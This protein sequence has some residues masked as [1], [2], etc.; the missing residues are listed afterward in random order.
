LIN[1][2]PDI[3]FAGAGDRGY[4]GAP[5]THVRT[6]RYACFATWFANELVA[7]ILLGSTLSA[8]CLA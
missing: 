4:R 1:D 2:A 5:A 7:A 6:A 3:R 8:L